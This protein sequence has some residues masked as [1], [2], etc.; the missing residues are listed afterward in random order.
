VFDEF[1]ALTESLEFE[2]AGQLTLVRFERNGP[3]ATVTVD[4]RSNAAYGFPAQAWRLSCTDLRGWQ[5]GPSPLDGAELLA[6]HVLLAP[7][8]D[9]HVTLGLKG[10]VRDARHAVADLWERHRAVASTWL[11]FG[12]YFN[13]GLPLAD[14]LV[15]TSALLAEGPRRVLAAYADVVAAHGAEA[16]EIAARPPKRWT[17]T[18][19]EDERRDVDLLVLGDDTWLVGN[20]FSAE[21]TEA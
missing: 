13:P 15:C 19:W 8:R 7:Y 17:G 14:L 10:A 9:D 11:P 16:Y 21:R 6:D 12:A 20:G 2:E 3:S 1:L 5:L 18:Y 4:L